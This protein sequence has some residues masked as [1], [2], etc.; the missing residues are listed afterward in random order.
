MPKDTTALTIQGPDNGSG[1]PVAV[2]FTP[3]GT[4]NVNVV[5]FASANVVTTAAG[6]PKISIA[7]SAGNAYAATIPVS[8]AATQAT[9]VAQFGGA[10]VVT[11]VAGVPKISIADSAGNAYAATIPVSIAATQATNVAQFGGSNVVTTAAGVPKISIA[12]SAG[13]AYGAT[14]PVS[15]AATQAVNVSQFGGS[16]VVAATAGVPRVGITDSA[17]AVLTAF[18]NTT[19]AN[20]LQIEMTGGL[21]TRSNP[22]A[23]TAAVVTIAAIAGQ[24]IRLDSATFNYFGA[25]T[26]QSLTVADGATQVLNITVQASQNSIVQLTFPNGGVVGTSGNAMTITLPAGGAG[27][28]G[29]LNTQTRQF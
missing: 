27:V 10:N 3:S 14:I 11:T 19:P 9:N 1:N 26:A 29:N 5:Q 25:N 22:A 17:G 24:R 16:A 4:T 13:T 7:D 18:A 21:S 28:S 12:D 20:A 8:I 2:T 15:I 6:V 23:N